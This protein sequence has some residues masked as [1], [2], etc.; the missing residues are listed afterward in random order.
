MYVYV[1]VDL[2]DMIL[3]VDTRPSCLSHARLKSWEC[4]EM[5][6]L[7]HDIPILLDCPAT[8]R[9]IHYCQYILVYTI[10]KTI[11]ST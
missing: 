5:R 8:M 11:I 6:Q 3:H 2:M 7:T 1:T 9:D 10:H 4:P